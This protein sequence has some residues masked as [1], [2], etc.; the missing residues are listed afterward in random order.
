MRRFLLP[1]ILLLTAVASGRA[2]LAVEITVLYPQPY[3]YQAPIEE[4]VKAF[5]EK[6]PDIQVKLL[7]PTKAYEETASAVLRGAITGSMPDV[8][9]NGTNLMHLFVDRKLAVALDGFVSKEADWD[10]QGYVPGM[11]ST[12]KVNGQLYGL[13]FALS[14]PI[15]YMNVDLLRK[16]GGNPDAP[17]QTWPELLAL[18]HKITDPA[19]NTHGAYMLWTTTGNYLW[20]ELLF[21]HDGEMLSADGKKVGFDTPAGLKTFEILRDLVTEGGMPNLTDDQGTQAFIAGQIGFYLGSSARVNSLMGKV[22]KRFELRTAPFPSPRPDSKIVSGGGTMMIFAKDP[23][24]QAAAWDFIKF[25]AGPIGQ[26]IMVRHIGYM[27]SNQIAIDTPELLGDYYKN[28]PNMRTAISQLAR[29]R[30]WLGF[31]GENS[32]KAIQVIYDNMEAVVAGKATPEV[33]LQRSAT[34]VQALLPK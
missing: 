3:L 32:L 26:T 12:G 30:P 25:A 5:A 15:L 16:A 19:G 24:K 22:G 14:T 6:R 2:A 10:K 11:I 8:A 31:P 7:A 34:Q 18:A 20:Q 9:F 21:T 29:T 4:I 23:A 1:F 33:A 17:P 13:P 27:P 28:N